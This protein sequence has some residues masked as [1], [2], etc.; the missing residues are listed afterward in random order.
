[1]TTSAPPTYLTRAQEW[2][3]TVCVAVVTANAYYIHPIISEVA[4]DFAISEARIG[5]HPAGAA[6]RG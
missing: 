2:A 5:I 6:L 4:R 3:L 1:M